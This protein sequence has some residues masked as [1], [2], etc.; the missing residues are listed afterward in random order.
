MNLNRKDQILKCIVEEFIKTAEP[1]GSAT[2]LDNYH[3]ACSSATIRNTMVVLEKEGLIEKTHV[4]SGRVPSAKGYQYYLDHLDG[5]SLMN[6]VDME[7]QREF[8]RAL[9]SK[10]QSIEDV[11]GKSCELLSELTKMAT[12]VLGPKAEEESLVSAQLI[13]I[14]ENTVL[15]IFITDSGYVEKK[16][17]VLDKDKGLTYENLASAFHLMNERLN[18]TKISDLLSKVRSLEPVMAKTLGKS[19]DV[20]MQSFLSALMSFAQKRFKVYGQKNLLSL[21]EFHNDSKAF[22]N[23]VEALENPDKIQHD[24]FTTDDI[25]SVNIGFTN[26]SLGDLAIVSKKLTDKD[27]IAIVGPKR[28][29]Y[30][31]ILSAL[32]YV[33][34]MLDRYFTVSSD[35]NKNALVPVSEPE[36]ITPKKNDK[37]TSNHKR[38]GGQRK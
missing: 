1:I 3:L 5:D 15:G 26:D 9:S 33:S 24:I 34:Y 4:S 37:K 35:V 21:P 7:F 20:I 6:S 13:R 23:A 8:Q 31:K 25:G 27:Q 19:G 12:V 28:M 2:L 18:G 16:T 10:T 14:T 36:N 38:K 30:K 11:L 32:E 22:M 29:D 17:F